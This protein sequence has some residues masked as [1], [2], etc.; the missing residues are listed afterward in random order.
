MKGVSQNS[1]CCLTINAGSS[2]VKFSVFDTSTNRQRNASFG[3][4]PKKR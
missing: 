1:F 4:D 3:C 2:S